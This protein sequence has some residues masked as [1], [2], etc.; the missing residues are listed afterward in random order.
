LKAIFRSSREREEWR[1]TVDVFVDGLW[2][3]VQQVA[4]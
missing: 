2:T 3:V 1:A 4:V